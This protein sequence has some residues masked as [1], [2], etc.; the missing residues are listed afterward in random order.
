[1]LRAMSSLTPTFALLALGALAALGVYAE[2]H[3]VPDQP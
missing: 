2:I 1:M 3:R